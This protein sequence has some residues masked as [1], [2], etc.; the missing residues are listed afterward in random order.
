M[1]HPF[2]NDLLFKSSPESD[3]GPETRLKQPEICFILDQKNLAVFTVRNIVSVSGRMRK[4]CASVFFIT[5][6]GCPPGGY[7][8]PRIRPGHRKRHGA[9][10]PETCSNFPA[11]FRTFLCRKPSATLK[12]PGHRT[13]VHRTAGVRPQGRSIVLYFA[14]RPTRSR[15]AEQYRAAR[16]VSRR[17]TLGCYQESHF[18]WQLVCAARRPCPAPCCAVAALFGIVPGGFVLGTGCPTLAI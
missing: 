12:K 9:A 18:F 6:F 15:H 1:E 10:Q 13:A 8:C 7:P 3:S 2:V 11:L 14:H 4:V 16:D 5:T 17:L